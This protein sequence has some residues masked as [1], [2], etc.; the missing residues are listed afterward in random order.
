MSLDHC[1]VQKLDADTVG[2]VK[3]FGCFVWLFPYS[4]VRL[5]HLSQSQIVGEIVFVHMHSFTFPPVS[6][7]ETLA[8][9]SS[10]SHVNI[11]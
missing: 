9:E 7:P 3:G 5:L 10:L 4:L 6:F 1:L 11:F 2:L 8:L